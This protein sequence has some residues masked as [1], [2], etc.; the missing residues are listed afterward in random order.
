ME[1]C[2]LSEI[3]WG[4]LS[5]GFG[6]LSNPGYCDLSGNVLGDTISVLAESIK[7]WGTNTT[8]EDLYLRDC[9]ITAEG[10][11]KLLEALEVCTNL[12]ILDLSNNTI[13]GSF[14][15]LISKPVYSRLFKLHL[16]GTSLTS[17]DIQAIDSLIKENKIPRLNLLY[18]SYVNLDNL[19]LDTLETLESLSSIIHNLLR[20]CFY[21]EDHPQD[22]KKIQERITRGILKH[23]SQNIK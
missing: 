23:K 20:V 15:A 14:D 3:K 22:L 19:E 18:L 9:N 4:K 12:E 6:Q 10:C 17:G 2:N 13:G 21:K 1:D 5:E 16:V 7:S 11:S 8:L